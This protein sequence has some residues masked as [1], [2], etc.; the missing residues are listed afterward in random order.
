[1]NLIHNNISTIIMNIFRGYNHKKY[2][3]RRAIV[4]DPD[5]K[6]YILVKLYY[7]L[8]IKRAE[9]KKN[10]SFETNLNS[11][12]KF[13]TPPILPHGPNGIM[14]GHNLVFGNNVIIYHQVTIAHGGGKI[15]NDVLFGAGSKVLPGINIG[16][17]SK[18]GMNAVVIENNSANS[19]LVLNKSRIVLK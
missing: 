6:S 19:T 2:W 18:I 5:R 12:S 1:M 3:R 9:A 4:I 7:L 15:G 17:G 11:G 10:C 13:Q 8:Y 14:L 16:S